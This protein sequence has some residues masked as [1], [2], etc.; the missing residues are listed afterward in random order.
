[1]TTQ[2]AEIDSTSDRVDVGVATIAGYAGA[3]GTF[4]APIVAWAADQNLPPGIQIAL[5]VVGGALTGI[6]TLGRHAQATAKTKAAAATLP[7][8]A[9][10]SSVSPTVVYDSGD[11]MPAPDEE[12]DLGKAT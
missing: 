4:I 5:I 11:A 10:E 6:T 3:V 9:V 8:P 1:M 7:M 12:I 2:T